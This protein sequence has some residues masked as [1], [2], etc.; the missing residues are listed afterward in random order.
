MKAIRIHAYGDAS[1]LRLDDIPVP[2]PAG[3]EVLVKVAGTSFNPSEIG[4]RNG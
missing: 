3:G 4:L 1:V 2:E